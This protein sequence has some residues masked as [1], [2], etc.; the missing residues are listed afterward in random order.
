MLLIRATVGFTFFHLFFWYRDQ[1][2]G[3]AW[4]GLSLAVASVLTMAGNA[5]APRLRQRVR[6]E[7]MMTGSLAI[8]A[9]V[10]VGTAVIGGVFG[11]VLLAGDRG[12]SSGGIKLEFTHISA[13]SC[14]IRMRGLR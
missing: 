10:G 7:T 9:V 11:G 8:I 6:E 1:D 14:G 2:N 3:L 5:L 13:S 4:F 12:N